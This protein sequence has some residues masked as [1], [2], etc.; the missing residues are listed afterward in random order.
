MHF[1]EFGELSVDVELTVSGGFC[2]V[3]GVV[4]D[5]GGSGVEVGDGRHRVGLVHDRT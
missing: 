2:E 5:P 3:V 4:A 1:F